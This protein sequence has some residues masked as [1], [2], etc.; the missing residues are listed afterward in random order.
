M[1]AW[2]AGT[3]TTVTVSHRRSKH[4]LRNGG[5]ALPLPPSHAS[6]LSSRRR[7]SAALLILLPT[8]PGPTVRQ[9]QATPASG[10]TRRADKRPPAALRVACKVAP[11]THPTLPGKASMHPARLRSGGAARGRHRVGPWCVVQGAAARG[12]SPFR[13][14]AIMPD[15][16]EC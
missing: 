1:S 16:V 5:S 7:S 4:I 13:C 14:P 2:V 9:C 15:R 10:P 11:Y 8:H 12:G 6:F 3:S